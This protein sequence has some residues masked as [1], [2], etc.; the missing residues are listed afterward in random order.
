[1]QVIKGAEA[2][3]PLVGDDAH[4][5]LRQYRQQCSTSSKPVTDTPGTDGDHPHCYFHAAYSVDALWSFSHASG[6]S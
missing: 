2:C 3:T 4:N 1:M 6:R 5:V